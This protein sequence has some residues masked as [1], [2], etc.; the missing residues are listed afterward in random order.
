[1]HVQHRGE[2]TKVPFMDIMDVRN[3]E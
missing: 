3:P 2:L 1:V